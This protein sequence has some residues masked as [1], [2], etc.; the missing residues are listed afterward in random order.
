MN[1]FFE[2]SGDFKIGSVLTKVG[3]TYQVELPGGKR[4]KVRSRDVLLQYAEN[5]PE[6]MGQAQEVADEI[7]LDF[8]WE[9]AGE[10][11]FGFMELGSEYFGHDPLPHEAIGLLL[12]LHSSPIYFYKKGKG[13]YK[14]APEKSLKA[15]L[16]SIEKKRQQAIIQEQYVEQMKGGVFPDAMKPLVFQLL[17]KPDKNG[18]EYKALTKACLEL[19]TTF[20]R[21]M[22]QTGAIDS[23]LTLHRSRFIFEYFPKGTDFPSDDVALSLPD[24]PIANVKAFSIDDISTTEIDDAFSVTRLS[25]GNI[26]IGIHIAAP[27]LGIKPGDKTDAIARQRMSTVYMPGDKITMLPDNYVRCFTL[28]AGE[29]RPA[30]SLYATITP[31]DCQLIATDTCLELIEVDVNLRHNDLEQIV[32]EE[33]LSQGI[34]DYPHKENIEILWRWAQVLERSRMAKREGFGLKPEQNHQ[35]DYNFYV[36][37]GVVTIEQRLRTAPLDKVIAELMI[38]VNSTWGYF[39]KEHGVPGIYRCQGEGNGSWA[40]RRLVRMQTYAA[41]HYGLGVDQYAWCTA[42]LRRYTDLVNQW[43]I[44]ACLSHGVTAPLSAPFKPK[45]ADLFAIVSAFDSIYSAYNEFQ[46]KMERYWCLRWLYQNQVNQ[47]EAVVVRDEMVRLQAIPL[48]VPLSAVRSLSRGTQVM[49]DL[50]N[51]DEIDLSVEARLASILD[52]VVETDMMESETEIEE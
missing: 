49:I 12:K 37:D 36:H 27:A 13:R 45:D 20:E 28:S 2:E 44:C 10:N 50:L 24:L 11:E 26:R 7:D 14:A 46:A 48:T 31:E 29:K 35:P 17:C 3:E 32:T 21:L 43:Q 19:Q 18:M 8:L 9:V 40:A 16:V 33:N 52:T 42:P 5:D 38:F 34:G 30:L 51:W 25:D 4:T 15:A 39:M 6:L 47:I 22:I 41:P 1:L 23:P